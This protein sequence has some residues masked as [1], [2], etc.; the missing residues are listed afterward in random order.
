MQEFVHAYTFGGKFH[1][2]MDPCR[3]FNWKIPV[4]YFICDCRVMQEDLFAYRGAV[5]KQKQKKNNVKSSFSHEMKL[6]WYL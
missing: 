1:A 3:L 5:E 4:A 2:C 6:L